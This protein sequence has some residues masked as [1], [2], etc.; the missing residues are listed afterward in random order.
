MALHRKNQNMQDQLDDIVIR[1]GDTLLLE[2]A[3]SDISR[4]SEELNMVDISKP[5]AR[6]YRRGHAPI[7]VGVLGLIVSAALFGVAPIFALGGP[8]GVSVILLS[9]FH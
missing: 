1:I 6:P 8:W 4:L 2:G 9:R 5:V 7:V 3:P